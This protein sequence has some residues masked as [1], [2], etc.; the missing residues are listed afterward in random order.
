MNFEKTKSVMDDTALVRAEENRK[1]ILKDIA[2]MR[3]KLYTSLVMASSFGV[4][5]AWTKSDIIAFVGIGVLGVINLFNHIKEMAYLNLLFFNNE[6][7]IKFENS[8]R[9]GEND[10]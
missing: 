9:A 4:L 3:P 2:G 1:S 6:E 5:F 10:P 7:K 8:S